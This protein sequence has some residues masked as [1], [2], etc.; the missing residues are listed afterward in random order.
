MRTVLALVA[1]LLLPSE[2]V[3]AQVFCTEIGNHVYSLDGNPCTS[4]RPA[5]AVTGNPALDRAMA[6]CDA[7]RLNDNT[8]IAT[9]PPSLG[10]GYEKDYGPS[11][12][13]VEQQWQQTTVAKAQRDAAKKVADD[14]AWL[15]GYAHTL[16]AGKP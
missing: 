8:I 4:V 2:V 13:A 1:A 5:H 15:D 7:H 16:R 6:I 10:G 11:C 3:H 9:S 14:K 12:A